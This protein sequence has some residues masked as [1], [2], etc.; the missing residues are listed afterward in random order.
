MKGTS[1][2]YQQTSVCRLYCMMVTVMGWFGS[3]SYMK[4]VDKAIE[5]QA[6]YKQ[7]IKEN[8]YYCEIESMIMFKKG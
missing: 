4:A 7:S 3:H 5:I 2:K 8:R 6:D 1:N